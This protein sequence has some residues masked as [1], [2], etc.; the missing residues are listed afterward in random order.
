MIFVV[1]SKL[2]RQDTQINTNAKVLHHPSEALKSYIQQILECV[3]PPVSK[4][5]LFEEETPAQIKEGPGGEAYSAGAP[6]YEQ[7]EHQ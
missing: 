1:S 7:R 5:A 2:R 3:W 6:Q 4:C